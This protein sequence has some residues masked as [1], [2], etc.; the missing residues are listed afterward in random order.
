[1][2]CPFQQALRQG[3]ELIAP[4]AKEKLVSHNPFTNRSHPVLVKK[5]AR[6]S[7]DTLPPNREMLEMSRVGFLRS[8]SQKAPSATSINRHLYKFSYSEYE[9]KKTNSPEMNNVLHNAD[10]IVRE[11]KQ[12][13]WVVETVSSNLVQKEGSAP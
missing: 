4:P 6:S 5:I 8:S 2:I 3:V 12:R 13:W 1:M 11:V 10:H 9:G 7:W